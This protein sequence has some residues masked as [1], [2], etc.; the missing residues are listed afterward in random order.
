MRIR[1]TSESI[2]RG[3]V[4]IMAIVETLLAISLLVLLSMWLDT[5][6]WLAGALCVAPLLLLRTECS[7][8]LGKRLWEWFRGAR[9]RAILPILVLSG[10]AFIYAGAWVI[11]RFFSWNS[12]AGMT[13]QG[14]LATSGVGAGAYIAMLFLLLRFGITLASLSAHPFQS[15]AAIPGNWRRIVLAADSWSAPE[16][17]PEFPIGARHFVDRS[18]RGIITRWTNFTLLLVLYPA[19]LAYRWAVK[20]TCLI[21]LPL[22]WIVKTARFAPGSLQETLS[23]YERSDFRRVGLAFAIIVIFAFFAKVLLIVTL[24]GFVEWWNGNGALRFLKIYVVPHHIPWW[25]TASA[26][27]STLTIGLWFYARHVLRLAEQNL[28]PVDSRVVAIWRVAG[29]LSVLLTI[30]SVGCMIAITWQRPVIFGAHLRRSD[31]FLE[32]RRFLGESATKSRG[33]NP[34]T[35]TVICGQPAKVER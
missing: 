33:C 5:A 19:M 1:S 20:A 32:G 7:V 6:R 22:L 17:L 21:Y 31:G 12:P 24:D 34:L 30:Y 9:L 16:F 23:S 10:A 35:L 8:T 26:F 2:E 25:Q 28:A 13:I 14:L 29:V 27:N 18:E 15:I 3:E 11:G 4:S